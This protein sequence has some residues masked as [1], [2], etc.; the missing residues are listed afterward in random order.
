M[1]M[2]CLLI[3]SFAV[4]FIAGCTDGFK[5]LSPN[6]GAKSIIRAGDLTFTLQLLDMQ[7]MPQ[8]QFN[9]GENFQ[10]QFIMENR[11]K[12]DFT[13]PV[14]WL[15]PIME[16]DFFAVYQKTQE[17]GG[18]TF[19][20]KSF[21]TGGNALDLSR[22]GVPG[23]GAAV[24]TIPWLVKQDTSYVMPTFIQNGVRIPK[25][26]HIKRNYRAADNPIAPL[27]PGEYFTGFTLKYAETDSVSMEVLFRVQ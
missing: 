27:R 14:P 5:D 23:R 22:A 17:S 4:S 6:S 3:A 10:F 19:I 8:N 1:K 24:Y 9:E 2:S 13:L 11:G 25:E 18:K 26:N 12:D 16:K 7:G 20:G 21:T 15:F